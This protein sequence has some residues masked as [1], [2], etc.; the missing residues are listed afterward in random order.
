MVQ[1]I[2]AMKKEAGEICFLLFVQISILFM[3]NQC[4]VGKNN[5]CIDAG[6]ICG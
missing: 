1:F 5:I 4:C 6:N 2:I 3:Q